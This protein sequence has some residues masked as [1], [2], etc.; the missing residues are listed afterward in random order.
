M[1]G[2]LTLSMRRFIPLQALV[3]LLTT[4]LAAHADVTEEEATANCLKISEYSAEGGKFYKLKEYAK[5]REQYEYQAGWSESCQLDD[6]KVAIA[7]NNVAL[8]YIHEGNYLK[9][10][11]WLSILPNDKKSMFNLG[12][13]SGEIKNS[14]AKLSGKPEGRYW[15]YAGASLW[16]SMTIKPQGQK[17][18]VDFEGYYAGLM[19]MY[20]GP[21]LGV[22]SAVVEFNNGKAHY[23]MSGDDGDCEYDFDIKKDVLEVKR[24]AGESCGFGHNVGAEGDYQR[25]EF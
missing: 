20:Y 15:S 22:F 3:L 11:A 14:L 8:T 24:T 4:P 2:K 9:A 1:D 13:I 7:Y 18:N 5:A 21:N 10:R 12:K 23:A 6:D 16:N 25:V 17:Y 19:A